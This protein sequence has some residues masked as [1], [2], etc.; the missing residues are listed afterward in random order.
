MIGEEKAKLLRCS[1]SGLLAENEALAARTAYRIGGPAAFFLHPRNPVELELALRVLAELEIEYLV[2]GGGYNVLVADAGIR[3]RVV[4]S[5]GEGFAE[6]E[7]VGGDAAAVLLRVGAGVSLARLVS[8]AESEGLAG[9]AGLAGIPGTVGGAVAMNAG[10]WGATIYD[11]L[12]ALQLLT[13]EGPVWR[14]SG[15]LRPGYRDGGLALGEIVV[16][17]YFLAPKGISAEICAAA[18]ECRRRRRER[19]PAGNH[20]GSV[21]K[22][23]PGDYA[24]RLLDAAGCRGLVSGGAQISWQHANVIVAGPEARAADVRDLMALAR[25]RVRKNSGIELEA[26]I[27][28]FADQ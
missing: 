10:A 9:F 24:G 22:N 18:D 19:L 27:K 14:A 26:E 23:P 11:C 5:L 1:L 15:A 13:R 25:R 12:A 21:F 28:F 17:A 4:I 3:D 16:A 7:M 2:L 6:L 20:A 8:L